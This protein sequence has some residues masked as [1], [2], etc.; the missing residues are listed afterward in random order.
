MNEDEKIDLSEYIPY[1]YDNF[2]RL[3]GGAIEIRNFIECIICVAP[4]FFI[5]KLIFFERNFKLFLIL[6]FLLTLPLAIVCLTGVNGDSLFQFLGKMIRYV[7]TKKVYRYRR[8]QQYSK[9][10]ISKNKKKINLK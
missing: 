7:N 3:F 5:I 10:D 9:S 4:T 2:G 8:I 1:N 6:L